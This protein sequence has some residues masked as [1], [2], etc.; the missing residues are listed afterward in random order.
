MT[1]EPSSMSGLRPEVTVRKNRG[2]MHSVKNEP[3]SDCT[4]AQPQNS[5]RAN[6]FDPWLLTPP[7]PPFHGV[8]RC[9]AH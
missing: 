1:L 8:S 7:D 2:V 3:G 6:G 4:P 9:Y 5:L